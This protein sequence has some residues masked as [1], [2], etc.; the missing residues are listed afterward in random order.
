MRTPSSR[1]N[2]EDSDK[3]SGMI[4]IIND[5]RDGQSDISIH[6]RLTANKFL[7]GNLPVGVTL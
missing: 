2:F 5:D 4:L 6:F 3:T 1:D 7:N